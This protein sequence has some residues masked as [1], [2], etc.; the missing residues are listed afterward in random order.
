[1]FNLLDAH[2]EAKQSADA[3]RKRKVARKAEIDA[4]DKESVSTIQ[5]E[6]NVQQPP[7]LDGTI[8]VDQEAPP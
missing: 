5:S 4:H 7:I 6:G 3:K 2:E 1:M 8:S